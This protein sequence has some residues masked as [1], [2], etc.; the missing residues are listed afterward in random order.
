METD[1]S[2][3]SETDKDENSHLLQV[4]HSRFKTPYCFLLTNSRK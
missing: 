3:N 2:R 1:H 4:F